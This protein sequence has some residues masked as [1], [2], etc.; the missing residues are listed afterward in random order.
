MDGIC[1]GRLP[2]G[3][4]CGLVFEGSKNEIIILTVKLSLIQALF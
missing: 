4:G 3:H 2:G 1:H